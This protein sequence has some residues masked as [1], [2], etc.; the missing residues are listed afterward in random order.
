LVRASLLLVAAADRDQADLLAAELDLEL[1]SGL[2]A[3]NCSVG[4]P[5]SRLPLNCTLVT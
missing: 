5:T 1:I 2:Q 4:L 3:E